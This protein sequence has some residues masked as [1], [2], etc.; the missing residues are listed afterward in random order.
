MWTSSAR[1][2]FP[3][4]GRGSVFWS[5]QAFNWSDEAHHILEGYLLDTVCNSK[6]NL[7]PEHP[8]RLTQSNV[9]P[10]VRA[11]GP[12][13]SQH[14]KLT[15]MLP[16]DWQSLFLNGQC[17][18]SP[19]SRPLRCRSVVL[20]AYILKRDTHSLTSTLFPLLQHSPGSSAYSRP[21]YLS[22]LLVC[23]PLVPKACL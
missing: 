10:N 13:P 23:R 11:L 14:V 2:R 8:H 6:V 9:W 16:A 3:L 5:I 17:S 21:W 7:T 15:I 20:H 22:R 18:S 1:K 19:G 12:T 4:L